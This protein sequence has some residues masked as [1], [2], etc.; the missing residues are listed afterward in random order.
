[1]Y[2]PLH[3]VQG[4][5]PQGGPAEGIRWVAGNRFG[6]V[7]R[8]GGK[9]GKPGQNSFSGLANRVFHLALSSSYLTEL[10]AGIRPSPPACE[11]PA[12]PPQLPPR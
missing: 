2:S 5:L 6:A 11:P 9:K 4:G 8:P 12:A 3:P 1:M 10:E 7:R